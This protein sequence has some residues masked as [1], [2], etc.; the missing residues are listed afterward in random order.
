[1]GVPPALAIL[2][3]D[4]G[5]GIAQAQSVLGVMYDFGFGVS[6]DDKEAIKWFDWGW[7]HSVEIFSW[8]SLVKEV[9]EKNGESFSRWK[10]LI[11][12]GIN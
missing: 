10:R 5:N 6:K 3:T 1:M 9:L 8:P 12:F 2:K 7:K 4:A 11:C